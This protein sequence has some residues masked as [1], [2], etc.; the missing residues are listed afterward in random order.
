MIN[1][2]KK[3][4]KLIKY[5]PKMFAQSGTLVLFMAMGMFMELRFLG[6]NITGGLYLVILSTLIA[7]MVYP[8]NYSGLFQSSPYKKIAQT[9]WPLMITAPLSL[10]T[11][12]ILVLLHI[13]LIKVGVDGITY[14]ENYA[15][16]SRYI[17]ILGLIT[18]LVFAYLGICYKYFIQGLLAFMIVG[19]PILRFSINESHFLY[20]FGSESLLR[21]VVLGYVLI[22]L[23]WGAFVILSKVFYKKAL[24]TLAFRGIVSM[25]KN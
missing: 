19:I 20:R 21:S 3:E 8:M 9:R 14:E 2:L 11:Y 15:T 13:V 1:E 24:S 16:Q 12:T 18:F 7:Q 10:I 22:F 6:R 17:F 4:L 23:G 5:S 25:S